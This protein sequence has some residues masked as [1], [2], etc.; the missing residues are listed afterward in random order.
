[1]GLLTILKKVK[2]E[3]REIRL[4][5]L[6]LD[7][8]GKTSIV[9]K[10]LGEPV[11]KIE[12]TLGFSIQTLDYCL[13]G[14]GSVIGQGGDDDSSNANKQ[15]QQ[16]EVYSL[17]LWDIG[18]QSSI[19]AY[20][21]NYFEKTDGLV[22]VVDSSDEH[23]LDLVKEELSSLLQQ[24]RLAGATLLVLANKQDLKNSL[25]SQQIALRLELDRKIQYGNRHWAIY[26]C[27]A[28][29]GEGLA[30]GMEWMVQDITSR[31]FM[32]N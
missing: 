23:R 2:E 32:L 21:R 5:I 20:W 11:D 14:G 1:M 22:F 15:Q 19:R 29:T 8:A 30:E 12:P 6:G 28:F 26:G 18:G 25:T 9:K 31:I 13:S 3:E 10:F 27:S 16:G 24:E 7:N 17:H 4:L